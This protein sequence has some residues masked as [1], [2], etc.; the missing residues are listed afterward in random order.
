VL[1]AHAP[2][3]LQA[4]VLAAPR[5]SYT[6]NTIT[7]P[8]RLRAVLADVRRD[9]YALCPGYIDDR[10]TGLAVP[11]YGKANTIIAALAVIV[12]NDRNA[13]MQIPALKAAARGI[14][15]SMGT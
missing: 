7:D 15:R 3:E 13:R 10:A 14:S 9:G 6:G 4:S 12:P 11:L 5:R 2:A 8:K 1:L